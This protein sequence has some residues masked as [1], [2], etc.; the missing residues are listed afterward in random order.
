RSRQCGDVFALE[1]DV[2]RTWRDRA[3]KQPDQGRLAGAVGPDDAEQAA[4]FQAN[5]DALVGNEAAIAFAEANGNEQG[6]RIGR[7]SHRRC[8]CDLAPRLMSVSAKPH[9]PRGAKR[10]SRIRMTPVIAT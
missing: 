2:A 4:A 6:S 1:L 9:S 5:V 3:A 8:S 10:M 7:R